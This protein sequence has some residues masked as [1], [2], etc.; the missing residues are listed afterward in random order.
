VNPA[1]KAVWT[2]RTA[3]ELDQLLILVTANRNPAVDAGLRAQLI[4][5]CNARDFSWAHADNEGI[6]HMTTGDRLHPEVTRSGLITWQQLWDAIGPRITPGRVDELH[7]A[8]RDGAE[9]RATKGPTWD[10]RLHAALCAFYSGP[11]RPADMQLDLF[12]AL[13]E[14]EYADA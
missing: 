2:M 5:A 4:Q 9:R 10:H 13:D 14:L 6:R 7:A 11:I 1:I 12:A 3:F 8:I